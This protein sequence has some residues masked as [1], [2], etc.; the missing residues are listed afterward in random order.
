MISYIYIACFVGGL[1]LLVAYMFFGVERSPRRV[2]A[3]GPTDDWRA[4]LGSASGIRARIGGPS[5]AGFACAFGATGYLLTT[6]SALHPG[7][8]V[9]IAALAGAGALVGVIL[10][11]AAWAV[12][13]ARREE[14][15]ERF[16]LQGHLAVVTDSVS[17]DEP[18]RISYVIEDARFTLPALSLDGETMHEGTEVVIDRVEGDVAYVEE[19]ARVEKRL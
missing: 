13:G 1:L 11:V 7:W 4:I 14:V 3:L 12:P 10:V 15:D 8:I 18:G 16:L 9:L 5:L 2:P 19:W 17:A 6:R